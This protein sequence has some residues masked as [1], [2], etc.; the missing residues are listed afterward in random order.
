M[1]GGER[2]KPAREAVALHHGEH[3]AEQSAVRDEEVQRQRAGGETPGEREDRDANVVHD[4]ERAYERPVPLWDVRP[5][6][7]LREMLA[8][9]GRQRR[10]RDLGE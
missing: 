9:L 5:E 4:D 10:R 2:E 8:G 1:R 7:S 3:G 6:A